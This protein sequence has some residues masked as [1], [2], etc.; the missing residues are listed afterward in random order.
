M[1]TEGGKKGTTLTPLLAGGLLVTLGERVLDLLGV[2]ALGHVE[3]VLTL[4]FAGG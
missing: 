4:C 3:C 2:G 1:G